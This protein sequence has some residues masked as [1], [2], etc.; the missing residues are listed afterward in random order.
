MH[1]IVSRGFNLPEYTQRTTVNDV[2][3]FH[4]NSNLNSKMPRPAWIT[5][6]AGEEHWLTIQIWAD[7]NKDIFTV[8]FE[9][10]IQHFN[11]TGTILLG[12]TCLQ[13]VYEHMTTAACL[14]LCWI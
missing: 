1:V 13:H 5:T 8:G 9:S 7:H 12:I 2:T 10:A 11:L 4:H 6:T 14:I 3:I